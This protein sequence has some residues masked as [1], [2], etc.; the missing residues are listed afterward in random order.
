MP[1]RTHV[2]QVGVCSLARVAQVG[3]F[4]LPAHGS[5]GS[6]HD[7]LCVAQ[8]GVCSPTLAWL[9][10]ECAHP[11]THGSGECTRP[12]AHS[13]GECVHA[14]PC[15]A[16]VGVYV[17]THPRMA[18]VGVYA[19]AHPR[20]IQVGVYVPAHPCIAQVGEYLPARLP[21]CDSGGS[22]S[23]RDDA[24]L[25]RSGSVHDHGSGSVRAC[26]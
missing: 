15:V 8:V 2:A 26:T 7:C 24:R 19:P 25:S 16:Q 20:V 4:T 11:P 6:V 3:V 18:Q 12:P 17:P 9:R 5:G 14:H 22:G 21:P 13:S 1:A 10:W 23:V